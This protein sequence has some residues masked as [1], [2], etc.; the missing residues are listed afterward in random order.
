MCMPNTT[1]FE[2]RGNGHFYHGPDVPK[3]SENLRPLKCMEDMYGPDWHLRFIHGLDHATMQLIKNADSL[4]GIGFELQALC[5]LQLFLWEFV[6]PYY[7]KNQ[8]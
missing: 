3:P 1:K 7:S 8:Y 2:D 5:D 6:E 4:D